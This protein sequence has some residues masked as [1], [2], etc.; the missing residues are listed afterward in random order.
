[1]HPGRRVVRRGLEGLDALYRRRHDLRP[2]GPLLYLG[3][4]DHRGAPLVLDDGTRVESGASVGMLHFNNSRAADVQASGRLQAGVRFA[5]LLIES[6]SELAAHAQSGRWLGDVQ[7]YEGLTWFPPH[8]RAV[9]F[10]TEPV[11]PGIRR[12]LLT[13]YFRLLIW[14][15]APAAREAAMTDVEPRVFR[16]T[17]RALIENFAGVTRARRA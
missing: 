14:G 13:A 6:L 5:R 16:I 12:R 10:Q 11:P 1:M 17:R 2:V 7:V 9:G 3:V 15:F 8:G 4:R